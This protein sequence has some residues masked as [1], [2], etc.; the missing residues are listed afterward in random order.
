MEFVGEILDKLILL[1]FASVAAFK[2]TLLVSKSAHNR[3]G[4]VAMLKK[5]GV[6]LVVLILLS[7]V[8]TFLD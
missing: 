7:I 6:V 2:P 3:E 8:M 1:C 4:R 5:I